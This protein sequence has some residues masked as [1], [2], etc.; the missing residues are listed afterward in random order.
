MELK[1]AIQLITKGVQPD[2]GPQVWADLGAG[3]GLFSQA[4]SALLP[5]NSVIHAV[6]KSYKAGQQIQSQKQSNTILLSKK[7]FTVP[8]LDLALCDGLLM[9]NSLHFVEDKLSFLRQ[10]KSV[11][12]PGGRIIIV[13]YDTDTANQWVPWPISC[14]NLQQFVSSAS[15]GRLQKLAEEKSRYQSGGIYSA[16]IVD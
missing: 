8:A 15:L 6:D 10:I 3:S 12:Q 14:K 2:G 7:D 16:L 13:E 9:A 11:L 4:L 1:N 5:G